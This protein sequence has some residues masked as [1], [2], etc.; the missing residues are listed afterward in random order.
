MLRVGPL[1]VGPYVPE[2]VRGC[3]FVHASRPGSV[4]PDRCYF[5]RGSE[6]FS[7]LVYRCAR[8]LRVCLCLCFCFVC[9]CRSGPGSVRPDRCVL[10]SPCGEVACRFPPVRG[11]GVGTALHCTALLCSALLGTALHCTALLFTA[12]RIVSRFV[13]IFLSI[14]AALEVFRSDTL[15]WAGFRTS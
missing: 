14:I 12:R 13:C 2:C 5:P 1:S 7:L 6:A 3:G 11:G 15:V 4:R 10:V 8:G 9:S